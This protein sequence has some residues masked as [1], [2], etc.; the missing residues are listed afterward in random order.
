MVA[1]EI[2]GLVDHI[3]EILGE[4]EEQLLQ[5]DQLIQRLTTNPNQLIRQASPIRNELIRQDEPVETVS[6]LDLLELVSVDL[7]ELKS[8]TDRARECIFELMAERSDLSSMVTL[9]EKHIQ[10][11]YLWL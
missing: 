4:I 2:G 11:I 8:A 5:R 6:W 3:D 1:S 9:K 7:S 10:V